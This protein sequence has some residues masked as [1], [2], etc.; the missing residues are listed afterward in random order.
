MSKA[1]SPPV[2]AAE[3]AERAVR[4]LEE[5]AAD[6]RGCALLGAGGEVLAASGDAERRDDWAEAAAD[7]L[8]AADAARGEPAEHVHVA[9]EDGEVF[10][11]RH[12]GLTMVAVA[13]RFT[14][15][16]LLVCDIRVVLRELAAETT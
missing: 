7:L 9:T 10:A 11:V 13:D 1:A 12:R 8:A 6:L 3:Q 2:P 5:M 16:S 15:G 14:L 4:R